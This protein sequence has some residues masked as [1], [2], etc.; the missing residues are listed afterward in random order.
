[1]NAFVG[2]VD[3]VSPEQALGRE[4]DGRSDLYSFGVTL[5]EMLT[6]GIPFKR[7]SAIGTAL[8]MSIS[9]LSLDSRSQTERM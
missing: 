4:L 8:L 2:T 3:Y 7:D 9:A 5:F 1:M 6:G